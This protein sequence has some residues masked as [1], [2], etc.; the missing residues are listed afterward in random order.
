VASKF[1]DH[2]KDGQTSAA[3][4]EV[5]LPREAAFAKISE[6]NQKPL[7]VLRECIHCKGTDHALFSRTL[8]NERTMLLAQWFYCVKLPP[9]VL[10]KKHP[11]N[12]VFEGPNP[13]HVFLS[14]HDG[15]EVIPY[16]GRQTQ[17]KLWKGMEKLIGM[18]YKKKPKPAIKAM[19]S[20][21]SR[22]DM[23]D[24]REKELLDMVEKEREK[25]GPNS[26]KVKKLRSKL[27]KVQKDKAT[28]MK[29][30]KAV[31]DLKLK[32]VKAKCCDKPCEKPCEKPASKGCGEAKD[33]VGA[34]SGSR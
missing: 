29:R 22:F 25:S 14:L 30:A 2:V 10:D 26:S 15:T 31:C 20:Y 5:A 28:T 12:K 4:A 16:D 11:F 33:K 7:L 27:A 23:L 3:P 1:A 19:L 21:L 32:V 18:A 8:N 24:C 34:G 13:P 6:S 17:A 9:N